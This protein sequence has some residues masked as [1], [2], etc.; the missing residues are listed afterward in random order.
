MYSPYMEPG[1]GP[2]LSSTTH[3]GLDAEGY[4]ETC[5]AVEKIPRVLRPALDASIARLKSTFAA[6][7]HSI[8]LYGSVATGQAR[9]GL[10]DIDI[11]VLFSDSILDP[12]QASL[13]QVAENLS[14]SYRSL[15]RQ[16][17]I[18]AV[19]IQE[20]LAN[21]T[22]PGLG[23]FIKHLCVCV[24]GEDIRPLLP[25]FRPSIEVARGFNGDYASVMQA[26]L[27]ELAAA[28]Q[29]QITQA[30]MRRICRKTVRTA[31]S[32]VMP[33]LGCW[34]T[35]FDRSVDYFCRYYPEQQPSMTLVLDWI[36][37]PPEDRADFLSTLTPLAA[38][39]TLEFDRMIGH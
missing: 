38:W 36:E 22:L 9:L 20:A 3:D 26:M 5:C 17:G 16:V 13:Q 19:S 30:V 25:K 34:T 6:R 7:L 18:E 21:E 39:L 35:H 27:A 2:Q 32:L 37:R 4:I 15:V 33:R 11:L 1:A 31:F 12:D 23:C 24:V 14:L 10:S 28:N 29:T 8:Y